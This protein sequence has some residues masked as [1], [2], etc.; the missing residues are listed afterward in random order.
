M[1]GTSLF[2][3]LVCHIDISLTMIPLAT[4]FVPLES[5]QWVRVDWVVSQCFDS[6]WR[7]YWLLKQIKKP[8]WKFI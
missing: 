6:Q 4:L 5:T 8:H 1:E 3:L 7:S 2:V